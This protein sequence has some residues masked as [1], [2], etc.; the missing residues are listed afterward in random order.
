MQQDDVEAFANKYNIGP[1]EKTKLKEG[2]I[3]FHWPQQRMKLMAAFEKRA[4]NG[5]PTLSFQGDHSFLF[6]HVREHAEGMKGY[7][8]AIEDAMKTQIDL[9]LMLQEQRRKDQSNE[10]AHS[11]EALAPGWRTI[12]QTD[13]KGKKVNCY[14]HVAT[15]QPLLTRP[16]PDPDLPEGWVKL[17]PSSKVGIQ[18]FHVA[19]NTM[20]GT[21]PGKHIELP[22]GWVERLDNDQVFYVHEPTG[23]AQFGK[24]CDG[25]PEDLPEGWEKVASSQK[26][27][28]PYFYNIY[29]KKTQFGRP[30]DGPIEDLPEGWEKV[31]SLTGGQPYYYNWGTQQSQFERP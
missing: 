10:E 6:K 22:A 7:D 30:C 14:L 18:Y 28:T 19:T 1:S 8:E 9:R 2:Y 27:G 24:P 12:V 26:D 4:G 25:P 21:R 13:A 16:I 23:K 15:G 5:L 29:V 31:A 3:W 20:T 11:T 17:E